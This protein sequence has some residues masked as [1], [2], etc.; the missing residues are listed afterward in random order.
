[1]VFRGHSKPI[2]GFSAAAAILAALGAFVVFSALRVI[3]DSQWEA[4]T[5]A[6]LTQ[7][8][9]IAT[10]ERASIAVQRGYLLTGAD[11]L[12]TEFW[13]AKAE[14]PNQL[15]RLDAMVQYEPV[16]TQLDILELRLG[17]RLALAAK[18]VDIFDRRGLQAAMEYIG[19]NGSRK[20]DLEIHA[21][22]DDIRAQE[23]R[24]L[25]TR[26]QA[27]EHSANLLLM[28]AIGGIP[29]SLII[30]ATVYRVLAR[31]NA[32]RQKSEQLATESAAGLRKIS[33][34][35]EALSK[36][37]GMLQSSEDAAELLAVTRQAL[38]RLTPTLACTVYFL[39]SLRDH[40]EVA[41][42]WGEH[43]A[44]SGATPLP[45]D[46]WAV[47]RNQPYACDDVRSDIACAH[48]NVPQGDTSVATVCLPLSA[49]GKLM[50][51]LYLSGPGP[52][53]L[54]DL[55]LVVRAA[56][57]LSLALANIRLQE[58]LRL[59]SI[60]DPLTGLFNRR[61]LEEFMALAI[62][63]CQRRK[64]PLVVLIFDL[65]AFKAFNDHH[66]H[67]GGDAMLAAF[68][69]LLQASCRPEDIACRYGG[70][71]FTLV[72]PE[73]DRDIGLRRARTI[74]AAAAQ[75]VV[76][77]QGVPLGPITTSI[78]MAV[79]PEHGTTS[80]SL[81]EAADKALYEAKSDGGKRVC[82]AADQV[83]AQ[84]DASVHAR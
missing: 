70:E 37:A 14:V 31:E 76:S 77:H 79:L 83:G 59:L 33:G 2:L 81:L 42:Q 28:A 52:G 25:E 75:M 74:L 58:D 40:A 20:L 50:G 39:R 66:G 43:G 73:A 18:T 36:Y 12:R 53:P 68:G 24:L 23:S 64:L 38:T 57:Q 5:S 84:Q 80:S 17:Q 30:L 8:D 63:R 65:D 61:Y 62:S 32:E 71:E 9:R 51:W 11:D 1:M 69:K 27:S 41:V 21:L 16:V 67:P 29:L 22:L 56:E 54:P 60:R 26:R 7:V 6:V 82:V 78:G 19:S 49:Q 44:P 4:H 48:V 46:C 10:L 45:T 15:R 3:E 13:E 35:M 55:E 34:D 47:R 72:L